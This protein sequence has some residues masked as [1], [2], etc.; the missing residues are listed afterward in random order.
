MSTEKSEKEK[1]SPHAEPFHFDDWIR[2]GMSGFKTVFDETWEKR[3]Q[4]KVDMSDFK[5]HVR[6]IQREQLL[7]VRSIIDTALDFIDKKEDKKD[8]KKA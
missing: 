7:A 2:E 3:D 5:H 6:N 4:A 1:Q 8:D